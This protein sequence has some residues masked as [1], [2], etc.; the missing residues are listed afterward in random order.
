MSASTCRS[1]TP[2]AATATR[3]CAG[4]ESCAAGECFP[5][6]CTAACA[7]SQVCYQSACT[8]KRCVGVVCPS[9]Q[10]CSEGVCTCGADHDL[11][12]TACVDPK[13][14]DAN[15]GACGK[16]CSATESC[17]S[18]RVPARRLPP[19][20]VRP[21]LGLLPGARAPS[22]RASEVVCPGQQLPNAGTCGCANGELAC[23]GRCI[24]PSNRLGDLRSV[25]QGCAATS[26]TDL[27][28]R[29]LPAVELRQR[30]CA[31]PRRG[32]CSLGAC[33][34]AACVGVVCP[35]GLVCKQGLCDCA[36]GDLA[37]SGHCVRRASTSRTAERA[38]PLSQP[39]SAAPA[40]SAC[41]RAARA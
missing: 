19:V 22:A 20:R 14:D 6:A 37:C 5:T 36:P 25:R 31:E 35:S 18:R 2:T 15:C 41:R 17:A 12:G 39:I 30:A 40:A 23:S 34:E 29:R 24:K 27:R 26:G 21:A 1:T 11:C 38:A 28:E 4:G 9:G 7:P 16:A 8:D 33:V 13:S 3:A 32:C 10:S